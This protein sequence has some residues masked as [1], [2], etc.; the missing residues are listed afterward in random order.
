MGV[1]GRV[2]VG[3]LLCWVKVEIGVRGEGGGV[4]DSAGPRRSIQRGRP[5]HR[6][7]AYT[8]YT[9]DFA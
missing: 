3:M 1:L 8:R 7:R 2:G 9:I 5:V 4:V 6:P